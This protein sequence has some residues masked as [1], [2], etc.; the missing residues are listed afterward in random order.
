MSGLEQLVWVDLDGDGNPD[1]AMLDSANHLHVFIN[2]RGGIF[3]HTQQP[4]AGEWRAITAADMGSEGLLDLV[5]LAADG[6]VVRIA[7][8]AT[9]QKGAAWTQKELLR[10]DAA[11]PAGSVRLIAADFDNNG[12]VDLLV[13]GEHAS[14]LWLQNGSGSFTSVSLPGTMR[15]FAVADLSGSGRLALLGLDAAGAA[16]SAPSQ[17]AKNYNWQT[18]RPRARQATGDQRINSFGVG[19]EIELRAGLLVE[20]QLITGPQLHFGLGEQ[21]QA[22]VARILWPNGTVRAEFALKADQQIVTEQRLKGSCPFLFAWNGSGMRFVKDSVPWGSAIGLRI[23][24]LGTAKIAATE[25][26][27]KIAGDQLVPRSGMYDLRITGELWETY[28]YD[29][30]HLMVVDHPRGTEVYTDERYDV[31]PVKLAVTTVA[32]P[33]PIARATDDLGHDVTATVAKLDGQYLDTFGRGQYQGVTRDHFLEIELPESAHTSQP[34]WLIAKGWLH[35]SDSSINVAL[36]QGSAEK[37]RWLS[38]EIPDGRGGWR[39]ARPNLGFPAGRNKTCMIDISGMPRRMR[40][41][42][43]LEIYW[44]QIEWAEGRPDAPVKVTRLEP[45]LADLHY[46]GFSAIHQANASSPELPDYDRLSG[47]SPRW[48]DLEGFYTRFGDVRE[49]LQKSDDRYVIMNAGDEMQLEFAAPPPPASGWVR[50]YVL[51]GDGWIK[52]GDYNS[53]DSRTVLPYPHHDRRDYDTPSG[54]LEDDWV[55]RHH[56]DDWQSYQTRYV[57]AAP[58]AGA[59]RN[60]AGQ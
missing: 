1:A 48:R 10:M 11:P 36:G 46:R 58:F 40:L 18:I 25:E 28:Y 30:M 55:Y 52:D 8:P 60:K 56:P 44:D 26:W 7:P 4:V 15:I 49:L 39:T 9:D 2:R 21:K 53:G 24:A 59:F 57:T 5:A 12:A 47:S 29:A 38:L 45:A 13:A 22:D 20:K 6:R 43:N 23:N 31:P 16:V 42:T 33:Q 35:P 54:R 51:A 34:L 50:D 27:Y 37:P 41:R 19:G 3:T 14:A 32:A 17:G